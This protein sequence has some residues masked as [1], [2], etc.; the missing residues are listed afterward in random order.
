V[1]VYKEQTQPLVEYYAAWARTGDAAAPRYRK[2][3][4]T[5]SVDD[6]TQRALEALA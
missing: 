2:I 3:S 6:I 4:G 5:G 1:A